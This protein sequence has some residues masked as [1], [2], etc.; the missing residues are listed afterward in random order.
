[1]RSNYQFP[2]SCVIFLFG[3]GSWQY[4]SWFVTQKGWR[5]LHF[6]TFKWNIV[7]SRIFNLS[8]HWVLQNFSTWMHEMKFCVVKLFCSTVNL[9]FKSHCWSLIIYG[10]SCNNSFVTSKKVYKWAQEAENPLPAYKLSL[11]TFLTKLRC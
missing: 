6:F 11:P 7:L 3:F 10:W 9:S 5:I 2:I 4:F 1:M 8:I